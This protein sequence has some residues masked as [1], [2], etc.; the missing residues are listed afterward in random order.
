MRLVEFDGEQQLHDKL[1]AGQAIALFDGIDEV[2]DPALR[3]EVATDIHRFTNDYPQVRVIATSRW[4]GYKVRRLRDAGFQHFMLQD[5]EDNQIEDFIQ[6]W[7]ELT[8]PVDADKERKRDR[9]QKAIRESKS[10]R[11]LAG[12]PLLLT[13]M[14]IL[15]RHQELPRDR[16]ENN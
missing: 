6:R 2:F 5:L 12:N 8:F 10:I 13:M 11:E 7:H 3:D 16:P 9:L 15:N 4:L 14:A 1:K